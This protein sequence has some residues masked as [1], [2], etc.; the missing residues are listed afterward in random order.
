[1]WEPVTVCL[2]GLSAVWGA[3]KGKGSG[4]FLFTLYTAN[5][6]NNSSA[7]HLQNSSGCCF[8]VGLLTEGDNKSCGLV[9]WNHLHINTGKMKELVVEFCRCSYSLFTPVSIQ[10]GGNRDGDGH[11]AF[12]CLLGEQ[13]HSSWQEEAGYRLIR[14]ASQLLPGMPIWPCKEKDDS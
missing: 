1:M 8:I 10:V 11:F 13:H 2:I 7:C 12:C 9:E 6:H 14:K 5:F 4:S 3:P